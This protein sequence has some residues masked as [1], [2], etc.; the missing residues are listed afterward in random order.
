MPNWV[1]P[2]RTY[3]K[4]G[5]LVTLL[6]IFP[7]MPRK[8][9]NNMS[10][11]SSPMAARE[12]RPALAFPSEMIKMIDNTYG[13]DSIKNW[14]L[15]LVVSWR[16]E[17][18]NRRAQCMAGVFR[19][20]KNTCRILPFIPSWN[21]QNQL[22]VLIIIFFNY[23]LFIKLFSNSNLKIICHDR[24]H[25]NS[26]KAHNNPVLWT[27]SCTDKWGLVRKGVLICHKQEN[28]LAYMP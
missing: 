22:S 5:F 7:K 23:N 27:C 9:N 24:F 19:H 12:R 1:L 28:K 25:H 21:D 2:G 3:P 17:W 4:T 16:Y 6:R 10:R 14:K 20:T 15:I 8:R 11:D 13:Q 18:N 26:G